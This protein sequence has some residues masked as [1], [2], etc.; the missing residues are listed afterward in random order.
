[1]K[2]H[3]EMNGPIPA[4]NAEPYTYWEPANTVNDLHKQLSS[5]KCRELYYDNK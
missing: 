4:A 5:N 2:Q 3:Y 1:M